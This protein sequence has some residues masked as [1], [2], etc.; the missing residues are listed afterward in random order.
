MSVKNTI[1]S[2]E[3]GAG[4]EIACSQ[5]W[6]EK[7]M[8]EVFDLQQQFAKILKYWTEGASGL[9]Q[10]VCTDACWLASHLLNL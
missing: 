5:N 8:K 3:Y 7:I 2:L 1:C 10:P 4:E 9:A 6:L